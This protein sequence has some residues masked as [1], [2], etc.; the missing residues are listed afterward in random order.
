MGNE[1]NPAVKNWLIAQNVDAVLPEQANM[2]LRDS[3]AK[4]VNSISLD[5]T[6]GLFLDTLDDMMVLFDRVCA[7]VNP[8]HIYCGA[9]TVP[10]LA[11]L[12]LRSLKLGYDC[13]TYRGCAGCDPLGEYARR[14]R[15]PADIDC[16]LDQMAST[17]R[18]MIMNIP[19]VKT[20]LIRGSVYHNGGASAVQE[21]AC[22]MATAKEYITELNQR[23]LSVSDIAKNIC[24]EFSVGSNFIEEIAKLRAAR[25]VWTRMIKEL[26]G[27]EAA[28][29]ADITA[30]T[31]AFTAVAGVAELNIMRNTIQAVAAALA[32]VNYLQVA[33]FDQADGCSDDYSRNIAR[34]C[35]LLLQHEFG[36]ADQA[37][38]LIESANIDSIISKMVTDIEQ[39]LDKLQDAG[40]MFAALQEDM[41]QDDIADNLEQRQQQL[42]F[43]R[44]SVIGVNTYANNGKIFEDKPQ[45]AANIREARLKV[46]T[47]HLQKIDKTIVAND[48]GKIDGCVCS[49]LAA[50]SSGATTEEVMKALNKG[51]MVSITPIIPHRLTEQFAYLRARTAKI[52]EKHGRNIQVLICKLGEYDQYKAKA[53]LAA[54]IMRIA[55]F[56]IIDNE[57]YADTALA[58][59]ALK[60]SAADA[61]VVCAADEDYLNIAADIKAAVPQIRLLIIGAPAAESRK[62]YSAAGVDDYIHENVD[63]LAVLRAIQD[64][65][66]E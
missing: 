20:I 16:Y 39:Y 40:G 13:K 22:C 35:Q 65:Y 53:V 9:T 10:F 27:N 66:G 58:V 57:A 14:G 11:L 31:S 17:M 6:G 46:R 59:S 50:F 4:G 23:G 51:K 54:S 28:Q 33:P 60:N 36:L 62:L 37:C 45:I 29:Q 47:A 2:I 55:D 52:K 41:P 19:H 25:L 7:R 63:C 15:L 44:D 42:A 12:K 18:W 49:V 3:I 24:L 26:G 5:L 21:V 61:V 30:R 34:N 48:I 8:M 56:E 32:G 1:N 64:V 38:L 43:R